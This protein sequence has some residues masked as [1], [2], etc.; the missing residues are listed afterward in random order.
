M[1]DLIQR[2]MI[3]QDLLIQTFLFNQKMDYSQMVEEPN[4]PRINAQNQEKKLR[5]S[6]SLKMM[7]LV[8]VLIK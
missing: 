8:Q 1:E 2:E 4:S 7:V 3:G 5:L 6:K